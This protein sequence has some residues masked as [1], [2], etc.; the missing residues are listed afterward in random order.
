MMT[1][2]DKNGAPNTKGNEYNNG[3]NRGGNEHLI[4]LTT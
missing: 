2:N 3:H 4:I 1:K